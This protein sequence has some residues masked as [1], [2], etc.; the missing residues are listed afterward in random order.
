ML[1]GVSDLDVS[2]QTT[3]KETTWAWLPHLLAFV[4]VQRVESH[5]SCPA[6]EEATV[7][8]GTMDLSK[9]MPRTSS[10]PA[11]SAKAS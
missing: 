1:S 9:W 4:P 2:A 3:Y 11:V 8:L 7:L 5:S 10:L 6:A